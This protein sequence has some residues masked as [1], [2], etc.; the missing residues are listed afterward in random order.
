MVTDEERRRV[1]QNLR[2]G[3]DIVGDAGGRFWLNGTLFGLDISAR[4]E[5]RIRCGLRHLAGLIDQDPRA[6]E[7]AAKAYRA[8]DDY[9]DW[10]LG[11]T[12]RV[13]KLREQAKELEA[14]ARERELYDSDTT[15]PAADTTKCDREALLALA[16]KLEKDAAYDE[17]SEDL[18]SAWYLADVL[19]DAAMEIRDA[20]DVKDE[21]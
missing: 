3:F 11:D 5:E 9:I 17:G 18:V 8:A 6:E 12:P 4:S 15:K 20:C 7:I 21:P 1:A 16:D 10:E 2:G 19:R 13:R 14:M